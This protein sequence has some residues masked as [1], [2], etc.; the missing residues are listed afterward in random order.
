MPIIYECLDIHRLMLR[1]DG[2]GGLLRSAERRLGS[3]AVLLLTSSPA[4]VENYFE[5]FGQFQGPIDLIENKVIELDGEAGARSSSPTLPPADGKPWKI[6]WFGALRC[7]RSLD[8]LSAFTRQMEGRFEVVLRGR[9][10]YDQFDGFEQR[11]ESEPFISFRGPYRNPEDLAQI[12]G[13]VHFSW[14]IDFFEEGL[15]SNWLLPNRLYEGCRYATVPI[16]LQGTETSRFLERK[17]LGVS[18]PGNRETALREAL[19]QFDS[20]RYLRAANAVAGERPKSWIVD[21]T[22]CAALVRRLAELP[23]RAGGI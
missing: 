15:N 10:A 1:T 13:E 14:L 5:R 20:E 22:D 2:A 8:I 16:A 7:R 21:R 4:F 3:K 11:I 18:L 9:P 17:G 19:S 6:G 23:A 12:Y